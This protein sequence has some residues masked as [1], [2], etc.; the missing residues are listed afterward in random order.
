MRAQQQPPHPLGGSTCLGNGRAFAG[1]AVIPVSF[2]IAKSEKKA[3]LR[4]M[5]M[6]G[7]REMLFSLSMRRDGWHNPFFFFLVSSPPHSIPGYLHQAGAGHPG[8]QHVPSP[9]FNPVGSS[10]EEQ[11]FY[12]SSLLLH[13]PATH[14]I[15]VLTAE[16]QATRP[17]ASGLQH[18]G[19]ALAVSARA[20]P[21]L[22]C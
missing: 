13:L 21:W 16:Q 3:E 12:S 4:G 6:L 17:L 9:M 2:P 14:G 7:R 22:V 18:V 5:C 8:T 10:Q 19:L 20:H 11:L 15:P 1:P